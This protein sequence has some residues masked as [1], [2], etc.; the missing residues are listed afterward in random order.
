MEHITRQKW[1]DTKTSKKGL[2]PFMLGDT[3]YVPSTGYILHYEQSHNSYPSL[4]DTVEVVIK[5]KKIFHLKSLST[6]IFLH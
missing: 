1:I 6:T 5:Q 4:R 3:P 2:L